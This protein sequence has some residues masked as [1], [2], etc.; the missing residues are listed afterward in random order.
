MKIRKGSINHFILLG[1]EKALDGVHMEDFS[2]TGQYK[3]MLG[4][5]NSR[6]QS[7]V[8][9]AVRRLRKKGIIEYEKDKDGKIL[10]KLSA[11]GRDFL[12]INEREEEWDGK[13]RIVIWDI[14][15]KK[16]RIRDLFR[17]RLKGWGFK[18][19]QKSVWISKRNVTDKLRQLISELEMEGQVAVIE[20]DDPSLSHIILHD[21]GRK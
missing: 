2:Y 10:L 9:E 16:R 18:N 15:E 6:K 3:S 4:F 21:R 7:S 8:Y 14:P 17:R 20:S 12:G 13:Y 11:L 1:L 19:W 5:R